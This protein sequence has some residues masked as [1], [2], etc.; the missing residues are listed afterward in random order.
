[1]AYG[2]RLT[3]IPYSLKISISVKMN[4]STVT[5]DVYVNEAINK[6]QSQNLYQTWMDQASILFE[7]L[8]D[9]AGQPD[10]STPEEPTNGEESAE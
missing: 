6:V 2:V 3:T 4:W 8:G 5:Y 10:L 1:M 7:S 9:N